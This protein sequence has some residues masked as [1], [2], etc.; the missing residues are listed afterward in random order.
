MQEFLALH[1]RRNIQ[2]LFYSQESIFYGSQP[3]QKDPAIALDLIQPFIVSFGI[4]IKRLEQIRLSAME[5]FAPLI[6]KA[7]IP[8]VHFAFPALILCR[9]L[10]GKFASQ[11][12]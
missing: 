4:R 2:T 7:M 12:D 3:V 9:D 11:L 1:G 10:R 5:H 8:D 6:A